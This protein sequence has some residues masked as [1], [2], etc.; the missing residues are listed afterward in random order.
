MVS[1]YN[2]CLVS[3]CLS[4]GDTACNLPRRKHHVRHLEVLESQ[5]NDQCVPD[6]MLAA[7]GDRREMTPESRGYGL[8]VAASPSTSLGAMQ[9]LVSEVVGWDT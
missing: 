7:R 9:H 8:A 1:Q 4:P 5:R 3:S 2:A 6:L